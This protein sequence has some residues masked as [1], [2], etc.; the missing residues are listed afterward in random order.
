MNYEC[1]KTLNRKFIGTDKKTK[2]IQKI[3]IIYF[4][5]RDAHPQ[6]IICELS[7]PVKE[8]NKYS[9]NYLVIRINKK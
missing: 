5:S 6:F 3:R 2:N 8:K 1:N 4:L 9:V 7:I